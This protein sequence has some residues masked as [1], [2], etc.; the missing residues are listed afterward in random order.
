MK[1][2]DREMIQHFENVATLSNAKAWDKTSE[3]FTFCLDLLRLSLV[4]DGDNFSAAMV[5][6]LEVRFER[7]LVSCQRPCCA[8]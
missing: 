8:S 4:I 2:E 3:K 5:D 7:L 1:S 6:A